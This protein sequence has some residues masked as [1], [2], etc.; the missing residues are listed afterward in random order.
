MNQ[1]F[2]N[3]SEEG[4]IYPLTLIEIEEAQKADAKLYYL[5]KCNAV[6]DKGLELQLVENESYI[7]AK[8]RLVIPKPLQWSA[9]MW[10]HHHLLHPGQPFSKRQ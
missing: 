1:I 4:E 10:Y 5:F 7:C 9:V 6:L 2:I 3:C 8:Q